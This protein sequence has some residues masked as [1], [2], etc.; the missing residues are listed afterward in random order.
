IVRAAGPI[1]VRRLAPGPLVAALEATF[2]MREGDGVTEQRRANSVTRRRP[3]QV[4]VR[5][6][7]MLHADSPEVRC[8]IDIDNQATWPRLRAR[9]PTQLAGVPA[10]AGAPFGSVARLPV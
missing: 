4:E 9:V 1:Q 3:G 2:R 6:V 5:F 10:V 8:L 7:L